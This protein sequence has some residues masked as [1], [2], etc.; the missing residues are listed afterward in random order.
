M[1]LNLDLN[2]YV[3]R[4]CKVDSIGFGREIKS[5]LSDYAPGGNV[6]ISNFLDSFSEDS[7]LSG[8]LGGLNGER[9][10]R[11]L[12]AKGFSHEFISIKDETK[13]KLHI[14]DEENNYLKI[15]DEEPRVTREDVKKFLDLYLNLVKDSEIICG[16]SEIL[17]HGLT[18]EIYY[19]L[20]KIANE[21]RKKFIL[22][23]NG[24]E[25]K[26]GIEAIPYMAILDKERLEDF[27]NL[28]FQYENEIIKASRYILDRGVEFVIICLGKD[29]FLMLGKE[30]AYRIDN[31]LERETSEYNDLKNISAAFAL[32]I[33][34][35]YDLDMTL[36]LAS[37]FNSY[38]SLEDIC[39]ID[40]SMIKRMMTQADII[41]FN[42][43]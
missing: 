24:E 1:I 13:I 31:N 9:Y 5:S 19:E 11:L 42:Y 39:E 28:K 12:L 25:F 33:K 29:E 18:D 27:T 40:V 37:A 21:N 22:S 16:V 14:S 36:R 35:N 3:N 32:G 8:F 15:L 26:K 2:P 34:R 10:H 20:I 38:S 41:S 7:F 4:I 23:A 43:V 17:P 30:K 6:I